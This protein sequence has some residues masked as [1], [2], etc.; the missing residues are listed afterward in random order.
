M[1]SLP[2]PYLAGLRGAETAAMKRAGVRRLLVISG[3]SGWC[4]QQAAALGDALDGDWLWVG[5]Q[6]E[7][8]TGRAARR[9]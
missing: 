2:P 5:E 4:G 9:R 3:A 1:T 7:C 8:G 6:S